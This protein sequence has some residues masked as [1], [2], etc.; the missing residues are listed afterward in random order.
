ML[1]VTPMRI[2][3][4][5]LDDRGREQRGVGGQAEID[6]DVLR[7]AALARGVIHHL[8]QQR[9]VHQRF[10]AEEGDVDALSALRLGE[11]VVDRSSGRL[12]VHE[13]RLAFRRGDL[14]FAELVAILAGEIALV[15]H[16]HHQRLQGKFL[17]QRLRTSRTPCR[18]CGSRG[19]HAVRRSLFCFARSVAIAGTGRATQLLAAG[20]VCSSVCRISDVMPSRATDAPAGN[21]VEKSCLAPSKR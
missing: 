19:L 18:R 20:G 1:T 2:L 3:R 8:L 9:E 11:Q 15:G 10:A 12:P 14:V 13:L 17:G 16:V 4:Q 6:R 7:S 21:E 5:E